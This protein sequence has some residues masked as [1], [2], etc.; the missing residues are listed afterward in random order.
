MTA[1][2]Y[3]SSEA[4][5]AFVRAVEVHPCH[6]FLFSES[7]EGRENLANSLETAFFAGHAWA[8]DYTGIPVQESKDWPDALGILDLS[9]NQL[10]GLIYALRQ[11]MELGDDWAG[12]WLSTHAEGFD[13]DWI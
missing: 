6:S 8:E 11:A 4:V 1:Y 13:V 9:C 3:G 2:I 7:E 10:I 5:E 12:H